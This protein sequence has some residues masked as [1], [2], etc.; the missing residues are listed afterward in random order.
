MLFLILITGWLWFC[1]HRWHKGHFLQMQQTYLRE[2]IGRLQI[3]QLDFELGRIGVFGEKVNEVELETLRFW[4]GVD[5][6]EGGLE[7]KWELQE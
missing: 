6:K 7:K 4:K 3:E 5:E 2:E 1:S